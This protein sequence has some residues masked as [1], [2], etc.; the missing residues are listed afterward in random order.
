MSRWRALR[1]LCRSRQA[2]L[3]FDD[4]FHTVEIDD[5]FGA[6]LSALAGINLTF[7]FNQT[8]SNQL[9]GLPAAVSPSQMLEQI[10]QFDVGMAF[11]IE[12]FHDV[13]PVKWRVAILGA[14]AGR[15]KGS[16]RKSGFSCIEG[17][18][19][20]PVRVGRSM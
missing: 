6:D 16:A 8:I 20:L 4:H 14:Q 3:R 1:S 17:L 19:T 15:G 10:A 9:L 7:H 5:L 13:Y 18:D 11:E 2:N 12:R